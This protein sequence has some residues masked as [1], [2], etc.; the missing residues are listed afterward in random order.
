MYVRRLFLVTRSDQ[1][2][3][4]RVSSQVCLGARASHLRFGNDRGS[5]LSRRSMRSHRSRP[6]MPRQSHH[7]M[8]GRFSRVVE[9]FVSHKR[10]GSIP[11]G[12]K[13]CA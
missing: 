3:T 2:G 8:L 9:A 4:I 1:V 6:S 13:D 5:I 11:R 7:S 10:I 12:R